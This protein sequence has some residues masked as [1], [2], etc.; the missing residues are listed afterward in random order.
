M[1]PNIL[2]KTLVQQIQEF[3]PYLL[4]ELSEYV[5]YLSSKRKVNK[6]RKFRLNWVGA[7]ESEKKG[8]TSVELQK[9]ALDWRNT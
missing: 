2:S 5:A 1:N 6:E 3:P 4:E 7:L 8:Y 9:K